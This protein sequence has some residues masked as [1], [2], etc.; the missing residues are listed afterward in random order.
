MT[1]STEWANVQGGEQMELATVI[2]H[3]PSS[4]KKAEPERYEKELRDAINALTDNL[5]YEWTGDFR[6]EIENL[7]GAHLRYKIH[8][9]R[10]KRNGNELARMLR[11][12]EESPSSAL[13]SEIQGLALEIIHADR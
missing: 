1:H 10:D 3:M 6:T 7:N 2:R 8:C 11:Q 4:I 5:D 12:Y 9:K 13:W